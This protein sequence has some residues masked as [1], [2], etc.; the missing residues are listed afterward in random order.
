MA[1]TRLLIL[2]MDNTLFEWRAHFCA[3]FV[4]LVD[5]LSN[6]L[7][8]SA[9]ELKR[10]FRAVYQSEGHMECVSAVPR[11]ASVRERVRGAATRASY[12]DT[13]LAS[14]V[15]LGAS[16]L[17]AYPGVQSTLRAIS[18]AGW[19][20]VILT[21]SP[22]VAASARLQNLG[23]ATSIS[24]VYGTGGCDA[25]APS[26]DLRSVVL[27]PFVKPAPDALLGIL[28]RHRATAASALYVG[29]SLGRD[30]SMAQAIGVTGV[31]AKY[32][33]HIDPVHRNIISEVSCWS[34]E[35]VER[36][37]GPAQLERHHPHYIINSFFELVLLTPAVTR[38]K[39]HEYEA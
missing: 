18:G 12:L 33:A 28:E 34:A 6:L 35:K 13:L 38:G 23:L 39:A 3:V 27:P 8:V 29:D 2:D 5:A 15:R 37:L 11:L 36:E 7:G 26:A 25:G 4:P 19:E 30:M 1:A 31:W 32:G 14:F 24:V 17:Q 22:A 20:L 10:Q 9:A 21:E 16:K